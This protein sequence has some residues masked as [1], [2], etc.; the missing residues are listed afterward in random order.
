M[1][2]F[3]LIMLERRCFQPS[4]E[5]AGQGHFILLSFASGEEMGLALVRGKHIFINTLSLPHPMKH[6]Y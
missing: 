1:P 6:I 2:I 5:K 4:L 3:H